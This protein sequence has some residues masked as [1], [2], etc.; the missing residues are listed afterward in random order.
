[1]CRSDGDNPVECD[2]RLTQIST[3]SGLQGKHGES[4][5]SSGYG[6]IVEVTRTFKALRIPAI[7][8]FCSLDLQPFAWPAP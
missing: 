5:Y 8:V 7:H 1:M 3:A 2:R 4:S 6:D